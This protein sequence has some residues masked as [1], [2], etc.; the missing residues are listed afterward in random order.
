MSL[1]TTASAPSAATPRRAVC[2]CGS[3][4]A[5]VHRRR[6]AGCVDTAARLVMPPDNRRSSPQRPVRPRHRASDAARRPAASRSVVLVEEVAQAM[7]SAVTA[8]ARRS[9]AQAVQKWRYDPAL[10]HRHRPDGQ[11]G[12]LDQSAQ[13]FTGPPR[14]AYLVA[15]A[16]SV[17]DTL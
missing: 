6:P 14:D 12:R 2:P 1:V 5:A 17:T 13:R 8:P 11:G 3:G 10:A 15:S 7:L 4:S 16:R 9:G